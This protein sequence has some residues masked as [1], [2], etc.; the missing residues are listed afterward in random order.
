MP[1]DWSPCDPQQQWGGTVSLVRNNGAG[2]F[3]GSYMS[4]DSF[5]VIHCMWRVKIIST[6][7]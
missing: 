6:T 1:V 3:S 2:S 4:I 5:T 7:I